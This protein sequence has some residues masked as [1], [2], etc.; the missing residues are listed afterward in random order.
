MSISLVSGS[1]RE[2]H[3]GGSIL[4]P[5]WILTAAHCLEG[6]DESIVTIYAGSVSLK[7]GGFAYKPSRFIPHERYNITTEEIDGVKVLT[8]SC[9]DIALIK[10]QD[11]IPLPQ[12]NI[13]SIELETNWVGGD[14]QSVVSGWGR[15]INELYPDYLQY[16][17]ARTLTNQ[18]CN[19]Y[20]LAFPV[21]D[22][23]IC[24]LLTNGIY[25]RDGDSGGPLV[26]N[27]KQIGILSYGPTRLPVGLKYPDTYTRVS[28]YIDW[29]NEHMRY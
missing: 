12:L 16:M 4:S 5:Q 27:G 18:Q 20:P 24:I 11:K 17:Y 7:S 2:H 1:Y 13:K 6:V 23:K 19:F 22:Y 10:L 8:Y 14:V 9:H 29:I 25:T 15:L 3:C 26:A 28:S 21:D